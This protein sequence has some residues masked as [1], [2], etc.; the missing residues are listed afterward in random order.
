MSRVAASPKHDA[1]TVALIRAALRDRGI[2][3]GR[4]A[5]L[6]DRD[7]SHLY[8]VLSGERALSPDLAAR[9]AEALER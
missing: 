5:R 2:T 6:V 9:I 7:A 8:R 4:L 1:P 3:S